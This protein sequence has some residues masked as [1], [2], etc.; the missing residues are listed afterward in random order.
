[1]DVGGEAVR[2]LHPLI[3]LIATS[4][5]A[6]RGALDEQRKETSALSREV[7]EKYV[8]LLGHNGDILSQLD[9]LLR[10]VEAVES[11]INGDWDRSDCEYYKPEA[12]KLFCHR[13][14]TLADRPFDE[15]AEKVARQVDA[16]FCKKATEPW[17]VKVFCRGTK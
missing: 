4:G 12:Q 15:L 8:K 7:S 10:R 1:M 2:G 5:C 9:S 6:T 13:K 16:E 14:P 17:Q 11:R 3:L